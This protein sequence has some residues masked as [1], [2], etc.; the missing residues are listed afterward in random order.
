MKY[1]LLSMLMLCVVALLAGCPQ[2][3]DTTYFLVSLAD[4]IYSDSY[5]LPLDTP[6]DVA[7]ARALAN[8]FTTSEPIV[9]ARIAPGQPDGYTN[10][11]IAGTGLPWSWH[12]NEFVGFTDATIEIYDGSPTF[13]EDNFDWWMQNTDGY[14]GFWNYTVTRELSP[15]EV[16]AD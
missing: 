11:D 12:V 4:D 2:P 15:E 8:G 6:A 5:V 7:H 13:V 1:I 9:V 10:L 3:V 16:G 14:I